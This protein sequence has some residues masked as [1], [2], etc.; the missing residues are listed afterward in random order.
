[1]KKAR[2]LGVDESK[3]VQWMGVIKVTQS[4]HDMDCF[5]STEPA[6]QLTFINFYARVGN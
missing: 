5:L 2:E 3:G 4:D 6:G 1:M